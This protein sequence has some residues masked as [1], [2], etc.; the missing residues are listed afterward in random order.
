MMC[1]QIATSSGLVE[2]SDRIEDAAQRLVDEGLAGL[3]VVDGEGK[4][5]AV[6]PASQVLGL[7]VPTYVKDD[8]SLAGV[9]DEAMADR[10]GA[11]LRSL[12]VQDV[13]DDFEPDLLGV[14][15]HDATLLEVAAIMARSH[16]PILVVV[17]PD[18]KAVGTVNARDVLKT[19]LAAS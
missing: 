4:P 1:S 9:A 8:P 2:V 5:R 6:L 18:G 16:T 7:A 13:L 19:V 15:H 14:V 17:S 12:T 11:K 10:M 3:A